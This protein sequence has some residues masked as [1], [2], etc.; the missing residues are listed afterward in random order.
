MTVHPME[1]VRSLPDGRSGR[2]VGPKAELLAVVDETVVLRRCAQYR[3][4]FAGTAVSYPTALLGFGAVAD[5]IRRE[6]VTVDVPSSAGLDTAIAV[7]ISPS[8]IVM[9]T[10]T[11]APATRRAVSAGTARFV[12]GSREQIAT[13]DDCSYSG[14]QV[15]VD[16]A[17]LPVD[18]LVSEVVARRGLDL[19]GL[20][21][22]L[23]PD[24]PIGALA[25]RSAI[26]EMSWIRRRHGV[27]LTRISLAELDVG[28]RREPWELRRVAEAV[29][30]L[31]GEACARYRYPR[32]ALTVSPGPTALQPG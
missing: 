4:A 26:A 18:G 16:A 12:V 29:Y 1:S 17:H 30:E 31:V 2:A 20:H 11:S 27:L 19:I 5:W 24:D 14:V 13:L 22:R 21:Y 25:L 32:P 3:A 28:G 10:G 8:Q 6:R 23:D 15:V 7:G 9:H